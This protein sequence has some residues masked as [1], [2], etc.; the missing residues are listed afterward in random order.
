MASVPCAIELEPKTLN[1]GQINHARELAVV[2]Q[3][4]EPQ[5]A[6]DLFIQG[7][8]RVD[9]IGGVGQIIEGD[10]VNP[11]GNMVDVSS[12]DMESG[13]RE[14][15]HNCLCKNLF[16]DSPDEICHKEPVTAP[17]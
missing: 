2:F 3:Q 12:K 11:L 9:S 6:S 1:P 10:D 4:I 5:E 17:F 14:R 8:E 15:T 16:I 7:L 13:K